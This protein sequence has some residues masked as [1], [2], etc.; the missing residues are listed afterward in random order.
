MPGTYFGNKEDS[1][2]EV[3]YGPTDTEDNNTTIAST[4]KA[5]CHK[6]PTPESDNAS[7]Q[8][9]PKKNNLIQRRLDN[10]NQQKTKQQTHTLQVAQLLNI[11]GRISNLKFCINQLLLY[12]RRVVS[13][14]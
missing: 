12:K 5:C 9:Q 7:T 8:S 10:R 1:N 3:L 6:R 11:G 4:E 13:V 14:K 2:E